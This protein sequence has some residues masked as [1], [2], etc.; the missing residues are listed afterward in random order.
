METV[1]RV[2]CNT[3]LFALIMPFIGAIFIELCEYIEHSDF[4]IFISKL[5]SHDTLKILPITNTFGILSSV[6]ACMTIASSFL[7]FIIDLFSFDTIEFLLVAYVFGT[8]S[9][10]VAGAITAISASR[11]WSHLVMA[12]ASS[13]V[14]IL[15]LMAFDV[16]NSSDILPM[17][18]YFFLAISFSSLITRFIVR[19]RLFSFAH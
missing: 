8:P 5:F 19:Q 15:Q 17:S 1:R 7:L 14:F 16:M 9:A 13:G 6:T 4:P 18:L 3:L 10:L 11:L 12:L 2:L